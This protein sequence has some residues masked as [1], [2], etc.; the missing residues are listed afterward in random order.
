MISERFS[1][2][3]FLKAVQHFDLL[4]LQAMTEEELRAIDLTCRRAWN[5]GRS[6]PPTAPRYLNFLRRMCSWLEA[7]GEARVRLSPE[8]REPWRAMVQ[9]LVDKGQL[10]QRALRCLG[11][12]RNSARGNPAPGANAAE[13]LNDPQRQWPR[14]VAGETSR[15]A[16]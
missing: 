5:A 2:A 10:T 15:A 3:D 11:R 16:V 8:L 1:P 13:R 6:V 9:V 4:R 7:R 14:P 12:S